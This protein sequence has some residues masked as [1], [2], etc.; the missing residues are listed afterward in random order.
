MKCK[1]YYALSLSLALTTLALNACSKDESQEPQ[2]PQKTEKQQPQNKQPEDKQKA[3]PSKPAPK[4]PETPKA[5]PSKPAPKQPEMPKAEPSK[6]ATPPAVEGIYTQA[7]LRKFEESK[8]RL[9][10]FASSSR[11]DNATSFIYQSEGIQKILATQGN[12]TITLKYKGEIQVGVYKEAKIDYRGNF[13]TMFDQ[14][15]TVV[16][17]K[18]EGKVFWGYFYGTYQ[19][20]SI[21]GHFCDSLPTVIKNAD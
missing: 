2:K 16:I 5:E 12:T 13:Y 21:K 17:T 6:P 3:E 4:Q 19:G 14:D 20:R 9:Y 10:V 11:M 18:T 8:E 15:C 7:E 1:Y